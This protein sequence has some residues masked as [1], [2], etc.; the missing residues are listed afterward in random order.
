[1]RIINR[2]RAW[3]RKKRAESKL[4][5]SGYDNWRQYKHNRDNDV[6]RYA[7]HIEHFYKGYP[8]VY[9]CEENPNHYGYQLL[10]DYG[11]G[12]QYFGFNEMLDWCEEKIRWGYRC[13]IHRVYKNYDDNYVLNDIGGFD[14][15]FFAF[16]REQDY[17]HF[18]LRWS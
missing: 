4:K 18:I 2:I 7:H 11:P 9:M 5:K 12:G 15:V 13:D 6:E 14:I 1:M 17:T 8:Y 16:K 3:I 10:A